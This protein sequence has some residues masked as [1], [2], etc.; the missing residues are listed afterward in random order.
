MAG[1][2]RLSRHPVLIALLLVL[3][4]LVVALAREART[5]WTIGVAYRYALPLYEVMR[6]RY[7]T[8]FDAANPHRVAINSFAHKRQL[9]GA[10]DR[11]VTMPNNDTLYS[12]AVLDLSAGPVRLEVPD[13]ADRYYSVALLD[14]YSNNFSIIGR[15]TTGTHA[16]SF[17]I[18]GPGWQGETPPDGAQMIHAPTSTALLLLRILVDGPDD[19][20]A[21]ADLQ[22]Q[23]RLSAPRTARADA[24][25][26]IAPRPDNAANFVEVVNRALAENPPPAD[27]APMLARIAK[28]GIA[29]GTQSPD[30]S[31]LNDWNADF[32]LA[33]KLLARA[34]ARPRR[35]LQGWNYLPADIGNFGTDYDVRAAVAL[36]GL[37]ALP[38]EEAM[39]ANGFKDAQGRA[40][41]GAHRYRLHLPPGGVP[42]DAFWSLSLYS[43][44]ADGRA[45]FVDNPL[46]RYAIG[47]RTPGL[48]RNDDGSLDI[49]IQRLA[50]E[51]A[52]QA[53][54]L[55]APVGPFRLTLRAYQ[56][57]RELLDGRF[58]Y[59]AVQRVE[60]N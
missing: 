38:Q 6:L 55:P 7:M 19:V 18:A 5:A 24:L 49:L 32:H 17:L 3:G 25:V 44:E 46:H 47:D 21:V 28:V 23:F 48:R 15:R 58:R 40:F 60:G 10:G 16:G 12:L 26:A 30:R 22:E 57:R 1:S 53:N 34:V 4:V 36:L 43:A 50:P 33:Q 51:Q 45:Y 37:L 8:V 56:P 41:D 59:P 20:P 35:L 39:Y 13:T 14:A 52:Q 11:L 31:T 54:W 42:A 27:D 9:A 2:S 29:P